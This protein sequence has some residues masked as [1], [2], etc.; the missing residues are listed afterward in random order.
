MPVPLLIP[1]L[2]HKAFVSPYQRNEK[3]A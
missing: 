3:P 1:H 2:L